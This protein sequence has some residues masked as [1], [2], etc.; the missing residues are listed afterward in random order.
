MASGA[1]KRYAQ[2]V[3]DLAKEQGTL[4]AWH[5]DLARLD[6]VMRDPAA[7]SY[8]A[9]PGVATAEKRAGL[10]QIMAQARP[11]TGNL[12]RLL[13][14]RGRLEIVPD[15]VRLFEEGMRAERGIAVAEVTTAEPLAEDEQAMV[16][17]RLGR[18]L[19]KQIELRLTVDPEIIGG[20]VARVG[21][22]LIDG[23]V[24]S[25]LRQLRA[26]LAAT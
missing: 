6:D 22:M 3:I 9:N 24:I 18:M 5:D 12:I 19:D 16:R 11:E 17:E 20:L 7:A 1:A 8:F 2:A 21:D 10:D 15:L 25:R 13:L 14:E 23:S 4:D 26:R